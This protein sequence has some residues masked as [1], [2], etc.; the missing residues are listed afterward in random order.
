MKFV[1][2]F[3]EQQNEHFIVDKNACYKNSIIYM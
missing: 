1:L 3:I 2:F